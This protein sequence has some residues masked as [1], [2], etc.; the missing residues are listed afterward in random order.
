MFSMPAHHANP[1]LPA[2]LCSTVWLY[3]ITKL[4]VR[5]AVVRA[6]AHD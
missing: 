1:S 3:Y 4:L 6:F 2:L 5:A